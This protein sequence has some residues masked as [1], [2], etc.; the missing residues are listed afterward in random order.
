MISIFLDIRD[1]INAGRE[2][3]R[4]LEKIQARV[5]VTDVVV[6]LVFF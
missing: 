6:D 4:H 1:I 2:H 3:L 5:G